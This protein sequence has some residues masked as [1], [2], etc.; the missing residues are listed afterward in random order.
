M[1]LFQVTC[2]TS[3][4][5]AVRKAL[6][7]Q[8][9]NSRTCQLV[10]GA[11]ALA[12][13]GL[14]SITAKHLALAAQCVGAIMALHPSLTTVFTAALP[15]TRRAV[16]LPDFERVLQVLFRIMQAHVILWCPLQNPVHHAVGNMQ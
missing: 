12:A 8:V 15:Q 2:T 7:G 6:V 13:A 10:L 11:G 4:A 14:R 9:F 5:Q 16:L 1:A 3:S